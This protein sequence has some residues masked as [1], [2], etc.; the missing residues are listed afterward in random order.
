ML[1]CRSGGMSGPTAAF[2]QF[3][4]SKVSPSGSLRADSS[5]G[6]IARSVM[7]VTLYSG[8]KLDFTSE[9]LLMST[10]AEALSAP[11]E[12]PTSRHTAAIASNTLQHRGQST[13]STDAQPRNADTVLTSRSAANCGDS[14]GS[15]EPGS[16]VSVVN[17]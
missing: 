5:L 13:Q 12:Q 9:T 4:G 2:A 17:A 11:D 14:A 16:V 10:F 8:P 1:P 7:S 15:A 3:A 6:S